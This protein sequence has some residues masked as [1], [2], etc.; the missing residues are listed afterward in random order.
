MSDGAPHTMCEACARFCGF[1]VSLGL[2]ARE[3]GGVR[4]WHLIRFYIYTEL[5]LPHF[6]KMGAMHPDLVRGKGNASPAIR[7]T[8]SGTEGEPAARKGL[9]SLPAAVAKMA[10]RWLRLAFRNPAFAI[11]RRDVLVSITPRVAQLEDGRRVRLAIDFFLGRLKSSWAVLERPLHGTGYA[12]HDGGGR[13]FTWNAVGDAVKAFRRSAE[14]AAM[15]AEMDAAARRLVGELSGRLGV[16][17]DADLIRERIASAVALE[18]A[19]APIVGRWLARLHVKCVVV[20]V[21]YSPSNLLLT[22]VAKGMGIPVVELQH[23]MLGSSH[24]AYN[25]PPCDGRGIPDLLLTWGEFWS[26]QAIGFP[27]AETVATGY[28]YLEHF[29]ERGRKCERAR[30]GRRTVLF[31]SQGPVGAELSRIAVELRGLLPE[32]K[33]EVAFK[34]HPNERKSWRT[35]YPW[36]E[37]SGVSVVDDPARS[38]YDCFDEAHVSVGAY[39]T[40]LVEGAM[41]NVPAYVVK[42]LAGAEM[43]EPFVETGMVSFVEGAADIAE[44]LQ[45]EDAPDG[46]RAE[47]VALPLWRLGSAENI[48]RAI[49]QVAS[50]GKVES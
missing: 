2:F 44:R 3:V 34:P 22:R 4:F 38:V 9:R 18:R 1:E 43:M 31:L 13:T 41:W 20:V 28:P 49:D 27:C 6:V 8:S 10:R 50:T 33:F 7:A 48:A 39:S 32:D 17:A 26:V 16:D 46:G 5:V 14:F 11:R 21:H 37:G 19:G 35:L 24:V 42:G 25:L 30:T 15:E 36:L 45:R 40:A 29:Y 47:R 23:G 12:A